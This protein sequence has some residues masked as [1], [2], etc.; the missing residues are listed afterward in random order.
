MHESSRLRGLNHRM[1]WEGY[2]SVKEDDISF[3][4]SL[5]PSDVLQLNVLVMNELLC[6]DK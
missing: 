1:R 2:G 3:R 6:I 4:V 5:L